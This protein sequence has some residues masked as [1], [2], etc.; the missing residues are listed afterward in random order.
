MSRKIPAIETVFAG[1]A[2]GEV[3]QRRHFAILMP[4]VEQDGE[5]H[6]LFEVRSPDLPAS[7]QPGEV[8]FPGGEREEGET[9]EECAVRETMEELGVERSAIRIIG[10]GN[11]F[12]T[13]ANMRIDSFLGRLDI[14]AMDPNPQE[15]ATTFLVPVRYFLTTEPEQ[16]PVEILQRP[17][18][19]FPY[20]KVGVDPDYP[21]KGG[22]RPVP[23]YPDT[24][25]PVWGIT[26]RFLYDFRQIMEGVK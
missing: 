22:T 14:R 2:P 24:E 12:T 15:V 26:A 6:F 3:D 25:Y 23:V 8:C 4:L 13:N 20:E 19:D 10:P 21:W 17:S 1:R 11:V 5:D 16:Y 7:A 9:P 18:P